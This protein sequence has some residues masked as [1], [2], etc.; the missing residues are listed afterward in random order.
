VTPSKSEILISASGLC[1]F[2][3]SNTAAKSM[4]ESG[5]RLAPH[6]GTVQMQVHDAGGLQLQFMGAEGRD[7]D[8]F[9]PSHTLPQFIVHDPGFW[10]PPQ[11]SPSAVS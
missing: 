6:H 3:R 5:P 7:D 2:A 4:S 9:C 1:T 8:V 10:G 11:T